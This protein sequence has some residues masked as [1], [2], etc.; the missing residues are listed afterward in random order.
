MLLERKQ[1]HGLKHCVRTQGLRLEVGGGEE[2][3]SRGSSC[4]TPSSHKEGS[5]YLPPRHSS[6][7][8]PSA[9]HLPNLPAVARMPK[10]IY[11]FRFNNQRSI[12]MN[13]I[14]ACALQDLAAMISSG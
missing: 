10:P 1:R 11:T 12:Q 13:G 14:T 7:K 4:D 5:K 6:E 8:A 9:L 2:D 3:Q